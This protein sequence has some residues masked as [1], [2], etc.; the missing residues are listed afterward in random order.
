MISLRLSLVSA[1]IVINVLWAHAQNNQQRGFVFEDRIN[2]P[3]TSVKDQHRTGTCWSYAGLSFLESEMLRLNKPE[4]DLSPMFIVYHTYLEKAQKYVRMH[5]HTNFSAGGA[6]HDVTNMIARYGIVPKEVY[7]GLNYGEEKHVHG[8][9]DDLLKSQVEIVVKNPNRKLSPVWMETVIATLDSYLG[10][11]PE[12][13]EFQENLYSP[14][15]FARDFVGLN[16]DDYIGITSFTHHPFYSKFIIEIPDNW[17]WDAVYN[18]PVGELAEI[19]DFALENGFTAGWAADVSERGFVSG[20]RGVAM[21]PTRVVEDM[22]NA[23]ITRWEGL[24]DRQRED[25]I[26]RFNGPVAEVQITQEMRQLAFDNYQTTDDHAMHITGTATDQEGNVYYKVK[27][28]WGDYNLFDGFFYASK[29]Y[30]KYKTV[31]IML[32]KDAVPPNI[33]AKLKI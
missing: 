2:L 17:S 16:M 11:I 7:R 22:T 25:E 30:F 10:E 3:V 24:T 27:N 6:F 12:K 14:V 13:F 32:H 21:V 29:A 31:I 20:N 1:I 28:S 5:G 23:E 18:V 26:Y 15:S 8:E 4:V 33:R 9:L 19:L